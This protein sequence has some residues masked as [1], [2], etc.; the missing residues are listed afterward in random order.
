MG[1]S[2]E[3]RILAD[4]TPEDLRSMSLDNIL[5]AD[6]I[7]D[8]VFEPNKTVRIPMVLKPMFQVTSDG[9]RQLSDRRIVFVDSTE[10]G[11]DDDQ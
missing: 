6:E 8:G 11:N 4:A 10:E 7:E 5:V 1:Q 3:G 2:E 9:V